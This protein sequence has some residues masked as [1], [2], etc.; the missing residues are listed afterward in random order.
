LSNELGKVVFGLFRSSKLYIYVTTK[1]NVK[2]QTQQRN[3]S[4]GENRIEYSGENAKS[5]TP[6]WRR[7]KR[8]EQ[9]RCEC[10]TPEWRRGK[11]G[12]QRCE[13]RRY[14]RRKNTQDRKT[15]EKSSCSS[16]WGEATKTKEV[17]TRSRSIERDRKMQRS[18][19]LLISKAVM[20]RVV[21]E[22][23]QSIL[24]KDT[25]PRRWTVTALAALHEAVEAH[26]VKIFE[27]SN[28]AARH[29]ACP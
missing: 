24:P 26:A 11:R 12:E 4:N 13:E 25:A 17:E 5:R 7:G 6:E 3:N 8:G 16:D 14:T 29:S 2:K 18:T 28:R 21:R 27:K 23:T 10:S 20:S 1:Y 15:W 22:I 9:H 19:N